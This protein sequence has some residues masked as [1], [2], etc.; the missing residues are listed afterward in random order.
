[1]YL[2]HAHYKLHGGVA[3]L[4]ESQGRVPGQA[5]AYTLRA[6]NPLDSCTHDQTFYQ[7]LKAA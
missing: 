3:R 4:S 7:D 6:P 5:S 2:Q 1:M